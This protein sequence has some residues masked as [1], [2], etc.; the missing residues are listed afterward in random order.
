MVGL[1]VPGVY[2]ILFTKRL[3]ITS[4]LQ[5]QNWSAMTTVPYLL[6]T[7]NKT[8][9]LWISRFHWCLLSLLEFI[10]AEKN[11]CMQ[12]RAPAKE[13]QMVP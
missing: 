12:N 11:L 8:D 1:G 4:R 10:H 13:C 3:T 7:R 5:E 9:L 2:H 6:N